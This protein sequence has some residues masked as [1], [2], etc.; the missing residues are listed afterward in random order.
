[1]HGLQRRVLLLRG[2]HVRQVR[3][4]P[5]TGESRFGERASHWTP[6]LFW[7]RTWAKV[8][9]RLV[10]VIRKSLRH[11][12]DICIQRSPEL[13]SDKSSGTTK[14]ATIVFGMT[15]MTGKSITLFDSLLIVT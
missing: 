6:S 14:C 10:P 3:L 7:K 11:A 2:L 4:R 12:R 13:L 9:R 8:G 1:M 15:G 5:L